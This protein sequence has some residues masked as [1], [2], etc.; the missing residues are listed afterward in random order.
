MENELLSDTKKEIYTMLPGPVRKYLRF[1]F[2]VE[3][4]KNKERLLILCN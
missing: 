3:E 1:K 2:C 4:I